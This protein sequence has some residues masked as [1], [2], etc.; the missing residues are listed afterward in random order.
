MC[1]SR[2]DRTVKEF[3]T[4][5]I[6][7]QKNLGSFD[8]I[9]PELIKNCALM[10]W[11]GVELLQVITA[12]RPILMHRLWQSTITTRLSAGVQIFSLIAKI[13]PIAILDLVMMLLF[14]SELLVLVIAKLSIHVLV[15]LQPTIRATARGSVNECRPLV[16]FNFGPV[17]LIGPE[18][19]VLVL[20][21]LSTHVLV[22]LQPTIRATTI[23][24]VNE[25]RPT[26]AFNFGPVP[27]FGI[28][29]LI[30]IVTKFFIV[31]L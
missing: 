16:T 21:E 22:L 18:L 10:L 15:L 20:A 6:R 19:L 4:V 9:R 30:R 17:L 12:Q 1:S 25:S 29:N 11:F 27:L 2:R 14:G 7:V 3:Q 13:G 5:E 24:S 26:V 31:M 8:K 28:E 23:R